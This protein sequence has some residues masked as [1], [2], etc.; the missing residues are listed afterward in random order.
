M[1]REAHLAVGMLGVPASSGG[2]RDGGITPMEDF[3]PFPDAE[4]DER[5]YVQLKVIDLL[6]TYNGYNIVRTL[7]P[8]TAGVLGLWATLTER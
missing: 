5:E 3:E 8:L 6:R 7:A 4:M 1:E 2:A